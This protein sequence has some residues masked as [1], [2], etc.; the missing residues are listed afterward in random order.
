MQHKIGKLYAYYLSK[1]DSLER[2]GPLLAVHLVAISVNP[3][4]HIQV[5]GQCLIICLLFLQHRDD[6][7]YHPSLPSSSIATL[8]MSDFLMHVLTGTPK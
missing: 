1:Q 8:V 3:L 4:M 6:G 5:Y 7:I 2:S